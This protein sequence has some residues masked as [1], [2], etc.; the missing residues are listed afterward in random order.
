VPTRIEPPRA[1]GYKFQDI[2]EKSALDRK[3][4]FGRPRHWVAWKRP[5]RYNESKPGGGAFQPA[6]SERKEELSNEM[7]EDRIERYGLQ[8][9]P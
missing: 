8:P 3:R 9:C 1:L 7:P 4:L 2:P 6:S 5:D